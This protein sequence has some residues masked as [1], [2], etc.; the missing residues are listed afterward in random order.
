MRKNRLF[1]ILV[2][3]L[4][5]MVIANAKEAHYYFRHIN[6]EN[7]LSQNTVLSILQDKTGFMWFGTKDGLNRYDGVSI[8]VFKQ[9][10]DNPTSIGNNTIWSLL[11][12][13]DGKLW[14][15]TDKGIYI[16]N[17]LNDS[18]QR[19]NA[20]TTSGET[21][22][23]TVLDLKIDASGNIWIA[24]GDLYR[25]ST[26][27]GLLEHLVY[28]MDDYN[29][30]IHILPRLISI[31]IDNDNQIWTS[32]LHSGIKKYNP[33]NNDFKHFS[34]DAAGKSLTSSLVSITENIDNNRLL[35]G[36]YNDGL[37]IMDKSTEKI[38]SYSFGNN[39]FVRDM[40]MF[41]D[42][43]CWIGSE[44]GLYI[45]NFT[46]R[47]TTHLTH[48][49]NDRYSLSDNAI[50]SLCE[51]REGGIWVGTYFGGVNYYPRPY[52][53]FETVYPI[54]GQNSIIGERIS[55]ICE[56]ATGN[57]WIG[58]E[59]A[60]LN[61]WNAKTKQFTFFAPGER[62]LNY[63]NIHDIV[64][65]GDLLWIGTFS[66]GINVYN[67]KT[68]QWKYYLQ[69]N[70]EG[71]L[72]NNDIFAIFK[73]SSGRIWVGTSSSAY[74]YDRENDCFI[75][76]KEIQNFVSDIIEDSRGQ[77][78]FST[79]DIGAVCYNPHTKE[80]KFYNY[81]PDD[82]YSICYHKLTSMYLDSK[83]QLWFASESK[84][85]C[86]FDAKNQQFTSF[87]EKDGFPNG[88]I[89]KILEDNNGNLWL[90]SNQGLI[91]FHPET[92]KIRIFTQSNGLPSNQFNYKSGY[93]D[94]NGKMCF[95]TVNGL[96]TFQPADFKVNEIRPPVVI[97]DFRLLNNEKR[98]A[99]DLSGQTAITLKHY[100]SSF[101]IDFAALSFVAPEMNCYA[102]KM[103]GLENQWNYL[104]SA[105]RITYSNL[106]AGEYVFKV[107]ASNN[108]DLWNEEGAALSIIVLPPFWLTRWAYSF[109][110]VLALLVFF[111]I[112]RYFKQKI[113]QRNKRN[114]FL[115]ETQKEKD[116]YDAKIEFFTN[117]AHEVRTPL[118]LIKGP[119]EYIRKND[120][121]KDE[122]QSNLQIME[123]NTNRLLA[124]INQL[125][126][127]RKTESK[128]FSLTFI[129]LN[130]SCLLEETYI[131]FK[132]TAEQKS[133]IFTLQL[134]SHPVLA[135][136][137]KEAF[138][139]IVSNLFTNAIKYGETFICVTL[140]EA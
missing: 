44:S 126:D 82:P 26:T 34:M 48:N 51:D 88:V 123:K 83:Q 107:K 57:I 118:T 98:Q 39:L 130:I 112:F 99:Q 33:A 96:V 76:Q 69:S 133:L 120:L 135:D 56:D 115:F 91:Q 129:R 106:P 45:H 102:Y 2:L 47:A 52:S 62:G 86:R 137:D 94:K 124:L 121:P 50:Y 111:F 80:W 87:G 64:A 54:T 134:P 18:F 41:S 42:R 113:E 136:V 43:N 71:A 27:T 11:E 108:D 53:Y 22:N 79:T 140:E 7:G 73:D 4:H 49:I 46:S 100:Q 1:Y 13:P 132:Q 58:S 109:Y 55:G 5:F 21:I 127:F 25:Y 81:R 103:E 61:C 9:D 77:I 128:K 31:N 139:K 16:Y 114:L 93:K 20:Q 32:I 19:M 60:G 24:T 101:S 15:G 122:L 84:G 6:T 37:R 131:R 38:T 30:Q 95:G 89:Y 119:L 59:D 74:L 68:K 36:S 63:H 117:V 10:N 75:L 116:I 78:W 90:S 92:E 14:A 104:P 29:N 125:L 65:D 85:I 3:F 67:L 70:R 28:M 72:N 40:K 138:I 66:H 105:Q 8:K 110:I 23:G 17:P 97:T 12:T 35:I